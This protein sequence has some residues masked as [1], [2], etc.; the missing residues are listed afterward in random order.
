MAPLAVV[1]AAL[2]VFILPPV[3][4]SRSAMR[5]PLGRLLSIGL[6][7]FALSVGA[8]VAEPISAVIALVLSLVIVGLA[9]RADR[10]ATLS[11]FPRDLLVLNRAAPLGIWILTLMFCA[12]SAVGVYT[13][14]LMQTMFGT[15][16]LFAGYCL[17][18]VALAWSGGALAVARVTG[19][20]V[21]VC[22]LAGPA[23][24]ALGLALLAIAFAAGGLVTIG[25]ALAAIGLGFGFSY[26]FV[27]QRVLGNVDH[28]EGDVTAG[29]LPT[30]EAAGAAYG[31]ALAGLIGNLAGIVEF[32]SLASMRNGAAW[33]MGLSA[34]LAALP[35]IGAVLL[36][37][38]PRQRG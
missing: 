8:A 4:P 35:L 34:M 26:T 5:F 15:M 3:E 31:A 20:M 16:P 37:R 30:L 1:F 21:E 11:L 28:G 27:T 2:V 6:G 23:L 10:R 13:P 24:Q 29:A 7:V 18:I 25:V 17:A 9:L 19:P 38:L 32:G 22:I 36:V 14:V 33:V 12:E